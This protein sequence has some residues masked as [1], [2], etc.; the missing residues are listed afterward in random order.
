MSNWFTQYKGPSGGTGM[1]S[2]DRAI[3]DGYSPQQIAAAV[4]SSGLSVGWRLRDAANAVNAGAAAQQQAQQQSA[5][6]ASQYESQIS[7]YKSQLSDYQS[8]VSNLTNQYQ[9]ALDQ[10]AEYKKQSDDWQDQ[11]KTK[12]ADYDRAN[13]EAERYRNEAVGRQLQSLRSG[14]STTSSNATTGAGAGGLAAGGPRFQGGEEGSLVEQVKKEGG[15]TDSVLN[16]KGPVVERMVTST[17]RQ[18][19]PTQAPSQGLSSGSTS[20]YYRSRF[21]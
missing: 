6:L 13:D 10:G 16:R 11:F 4:G 15:L 3:N 18:R 2:W 8:Q 9:G 14:A 5:N 17:Q 1:G 12:S 21:G 19:G 7:G 20:G